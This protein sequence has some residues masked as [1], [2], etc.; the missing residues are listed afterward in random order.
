[1][2][3][4]VLG[5]VWYYFWIGPHLL[6]SVVA[7][8]MFRRGLHRQFV[9]FFS[10]CIWETVCFPILFVLAH[11]QSIDAGTYQLASRT[12]LIGDMCLRFAIVYEI[13]AA[14]L[15]P[16]PSLRH[17]SRSLFRWTAAVLVLTGV[18][19]A[20]YQHGVNQSPG[21]AAVTILDRSVSLVQCGLLVF[22]LVFS[23]YFHLSWKN[24][25]VGLAF[26]LGVFA[27]VDLASFTLLSQVEH[28]TRRVEIVADFVNMAAY[29]CAVL[30]WLGYLLAPV[31][32][33]QPSITIPRNDLDAW[34]R[35]LERLLQR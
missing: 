23:S 30:I 25:V 24:F 15:Q 34:D 28:V 16:Y 12:C 32:V 19:L 26:G 8:L 2:H 18:A 13:F 22:I 27:S 29:H 20:A 3:I 1:M 5:Y 6:L 33:Q 14:L 7:V 35:E 17:A 4:S 10:Y 9:A 31:R 21:T 11:M